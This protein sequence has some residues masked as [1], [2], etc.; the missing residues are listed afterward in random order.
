MT[1]T[2][3]LDREIATALVPGIAKWS[4]SA[5]GTGAAEGKHG[6]T[7][8]VPQGAYRIWPFT[9]KFGR[10]AGYHLYFTAERAQP[11][12]GHGGLWHDLGAHRSPAAAAKAAREHYARSF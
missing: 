9:T 1:N 10:H 2:A 8:T 11:R 5:G 3:R 7:F 6:Y 4:M 12:G